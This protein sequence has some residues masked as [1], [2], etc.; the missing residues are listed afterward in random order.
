MVRVPADTSDGTLAWIRY[1]LA[2]SSLLRVLSELEKAGVEALAVKGIVLA[3]LLYEDPA[4]RPLRDID[5][6]IRRRHLYRVARVAR[7]NGWPI[8]YSSRQLGA[9]SFVVGQILVDVEVSIGPP[10]LCG[11]TVD[12]MFGRSRTRAVA[13]SVVREP[14]VIDHAIVLVVNAFKD[15]LVLCPAWSVRDLGAI[16]THDE[17]DAD[18]FLER[19]REC[20]LEAVT[21]IV[22]DW[23]ASRSPTLGALR[24]RI[25]R[26]PPRKYYTA[27]LRRY[28]TDSPE[29]LAARVLA[30]VGAD[31]L[32]SRAYALVAGAAGTTLSWAR[33]RVRDP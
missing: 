3:S 7:R 32:P 33:G 19:I 17:F 28:C 5:L 2:I 20:R 31:D 18:A 15:K 30:R 25:S 1:E 23:M 12:Q 9:L 24:D 4:T 29:G 26:T 16:V 22:A 14:D 27:M 13:G 10:G 6:R 8:D 21:W 11:L